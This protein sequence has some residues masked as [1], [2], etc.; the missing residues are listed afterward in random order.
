MLFAKV[1]ASFTKKGVVSPSLLACIDHTKK[2]SSDIFLGMSEW[3]G[4]EYS[5]NVVIPT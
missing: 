2:T 1:M 4:N 3:M 5:G